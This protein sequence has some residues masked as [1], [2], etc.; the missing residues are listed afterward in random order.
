M[1]AGLDVIDDLPLAKVFAGATAAAVA[2]RAGVT[3]GSFF[4][5]F[6]SSAEFADAIALSYVEDP[7]EVGDSVEELVEALHH[8]DLFEMLHAAMRDTWQIFQA[9][10]SMERRFRGQMHLWVHHHA[11]LSSPV[12]DIETVGDILRR[13]HRQRQEEATATWQLILDRTGRTIVRPFT[14]ERLATVLTAMFHGL[15]IRSAV[16]PDQV[17]DKLFADV[18]TTLAATVTIPAVTPAHRADPGIPV[19]EDASLSPQARSGARRRRATRSRITAASADLFSHGWEGISVTDVAERAGVSPQT[20]INL[21][22]SVR[23]VAATTF[24]RHVGPIRAATDRLPSDAAPIDVLRTA[25]VSL[26]ECVTSDPEG[27]RALLAE[28]LEI[29]LHSGAHL[30]EHD[31]RVEVPL[32]EILIDPLGQLGLE[33]TELIETATTLVDFVLG[34]G[35]TRPSREADTAELALRLLPRPLPERPAPGTGEPRP[36]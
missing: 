31:V 11:P 34:H 33:A 15:A 36:D 13:S 27:A 2:A 23:T 16:D 25:L 19:R 8:V 4:H 28:R 17:D 32:T 3:T 18:V 7:D 30:V 26:A 21:F 9:D 20:V 14:L 12:G 22:R 5:H 29:A 1:L 24:A 35:L 10:G 6:A